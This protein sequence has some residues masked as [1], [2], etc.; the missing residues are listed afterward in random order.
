MKANG[1]QL[2]VINLNGTSA[3]ALLEQA[4]EVKSYLINAQAAMRLARPHGRDYQT[5]EAGAFELARVQFKVQEGSLQRVVDYFEALALHAYHAA[6]PG[7]T[8]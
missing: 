3:G 6:N 1:Q 5:A 7:V 4:N 8:V 2:P